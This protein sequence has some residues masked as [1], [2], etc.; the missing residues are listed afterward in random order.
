MY[1]KEIIVSD[2]T[3]EDLCYVFAC[4]MAVFVFVNVSYFPFSHILDCDV[5]VLSVN[6]V[7]DGRCLFIVLCHRIYIIVLCHRI[8]IFIVDDGCLLVLHSFP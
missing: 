1:I 8:Y 3:T 5:L 7:E 2:L 6:K 4:C